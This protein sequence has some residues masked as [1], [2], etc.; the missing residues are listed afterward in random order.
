VKDSLTISDLAEGNLIDRIDE[1]LSFAIAELCYTMKLNPMRFDYGAY[2][3][4][5]NEIKRKIP[6]EGIYD[7]LQKN[8]VK[9][10]ST[11]N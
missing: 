8:F 7:K 11:L 4:G 9:A 1:K 3:F 2:L 5:F 10:N 6:L